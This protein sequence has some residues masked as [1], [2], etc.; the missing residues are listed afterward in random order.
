MIIYG[1]SMLSN[2]KMLQISAVFVR[3]KSDIFRLSI[4]IFQW[5]VL[6]FFSSGPPQLWIF[7][8]ILYYNTKIMLLILSASLWFHVNNP[9]CHSLLSEADCLS[10]PESEQMLHHR[11]E[12][13][14][15]HATQ[16]FPW[17]PGQHQGKQGDA[18]NPCQ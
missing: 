11:P 8:Y 17:V 18:V 7:G 3:K 14:C 1:F 5:P 15:C 10:R 6:N 13:L 9:A 4:C 16:R 2:T 12:H